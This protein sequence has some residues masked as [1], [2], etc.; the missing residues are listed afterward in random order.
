[1]R[2]VAVA[3]PPAYEP[4]PLAVAPVLSSALIVTVLVWAVLEP[5]PASVSAPGN[6]VAV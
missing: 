3:G 1:M 2:A 6:G 4:L 5:A